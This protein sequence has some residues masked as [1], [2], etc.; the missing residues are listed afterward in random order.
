[1]FNF[2]TQTVYNSIKILGGSTYNSDPKDANVVIYPIEQ[3]GDDLKPKL[4]IGNIGFNPE[5]V[6]DYQVKLPTPEHLSK[7][8]FEVSKLTDMLKE[9]G[10]PSKITARVAL[11]L[12]LSMSSQEAFYSNA[13]LY[14]GKPL[15]VEFFVKSTDSDD[16]VVNR[17]VA[18]AKKYMLFTTEEDI[19][20]VIPTK[21]QEES[22]PSAGDA[23]PA[24]VTFQCVNGY[25]QIKKAALQWFNP[26]ATTVDC[27][28]N[29][30]AFE[31]L[32]VGVPEIYETDPTKDEDGFYTGSNK[33]VV[34][35]SDTSEDIDIEGGTEAVIEPGLE[36][37][38][39]YNWIIHNLRLPTLANTNFWAPTRTEM[40][41][42]GQQYTQFILRLKKDRDGI[43]G[44]V[45]GM[46]ATSVTT[47]VFYVLGKASDS[48]T[49]PASKFKK[50]LDALF[51]TRTNFEHPTRTDGYDVADA[52]LVEPFANI[53]SGS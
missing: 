34:E 4:R 43:G 46:R 13:M 14:K 21:A 20:T 12:G 47:H 6:I 8:T 19:L 25:Q 51:A 15:Y 32:V 3:D 9:E 24:S 7:V 31:D 42:P 16:D 53:K 28:T 11:Y 36:A 29:Q 26:E 52:A 5:D 38:G 44:E 1:M 18:I 40:P 49:D 48:G 17:I 27:C 2:T 23:V 30:G 10:A 45:V 39:D 35:G 33:K 41:V 22:A 37:F 50:E